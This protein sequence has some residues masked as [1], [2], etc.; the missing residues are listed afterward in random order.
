MEECAELTQEI[1]KAMR[2]GLYNFHPKEPG[3]TNKDRILREMKDV[4]D[5][6]TEY[7]RVLE[8]KK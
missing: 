6:I 2:F 4:E 7:R 5:A 3:V 8:E 1:C